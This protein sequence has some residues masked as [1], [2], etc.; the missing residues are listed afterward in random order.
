MKESLA[1]NSPK[2]SD[3]DM[4]TGDMSL[5]VRGMTCTSCATE[6]E[7]RI[8]SVPGVVSAVVDY[9]SGRADLEVHEGLDP[10]DLDGALRDTRYELVRPDG[11]RASAV[12]VPE[13][14]GSADGYDIIVIGGGSAG[15]AAAI[16]AVERG[17]S[18]L[19]VNAGMIG[20]TC[21]NVGC[22]PSKTLI[23]AA[24]ARHR[25]LAHSFDGIER[26]ELQVDWAAVRAGKNDLVAALRTAK[27]EDVLAGYPEITYIAARATLAEGGWVRLDNGD[28]TRGRSV[29]V[30]TGS[31]PWA[32]PI[33]GLDDAGYLDSTALL[34]VTALPESLAVLGAGQVGLELAQ[35]Y[36]RLGV[37]VTVLARSRV[38]SN[39]DPDVSTEVARHLAA[40]GIVIVERVSVERVERKARGRDLRL[41]DDAGAERT[42]GVEEIL[43]ATG[44]RA[45]TSGLGLEEVGVELGAKGEIRVDPSQRTTNPDVFAVGDVTGGPMHVYVAAQAGQVAVDVALGDEARLDLSV[46]PEVTFTDPGVASVGLT[47]TEAREAGHAVR[48]STLSLEHV[49]RALAARD[50]RGFVKLVAD[51]ES[52]RLL[53]AHVVAPEAGEMIM[54]PALA[55]RFGLMIEDLTSM[56]HPYLTHAEGIKLAALTFDKDVAKLSCCAV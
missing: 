42:L 43:V 40:E 29:I 17:A 53:G 34:D 32:A 45:N 36:A 6:V 19:M 56:L 39:A 11:G 41:R 49:P 24:E 51:G 54:E 22:V 18:V 28:A 15:F 35:A 23:R 7:R 25:A 16:R 4:T 5:A 9:T 55:I 21:V 3:D 50:T 33:P 14:S 27:Y 10:A 26:R 48:A 12:A 38:L 20:G 1:E 13:R 31:S 30:A 52:R 37:E 8:G 47:E 2:L 46:L 44:R